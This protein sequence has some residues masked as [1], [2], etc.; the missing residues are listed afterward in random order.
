[1]NLTIVR[2]N[3]SVIAMFSVIGLAP[4]NLLV[5]ESVISTVSVMPLTLVS[6][7]FMLSLM[8]VD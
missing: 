8:V 6:N 2:I 3:E 7:L 4:T 5:I 1:M